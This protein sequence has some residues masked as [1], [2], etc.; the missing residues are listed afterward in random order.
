MTQPIVI[1][2]SGLA[3]Y[4]LAR[5]FRKLDRD[6]PLMILSRDAAGF[7]S[8]PMLSNALSAN[9]TAE[10]L[11]MKS[12]DKMAGEVLATIRPQVEIA[13][14]DRANRIVVLTSGERIAYRDLVLAIGADPIRLPIA[15]DGA[16]DILS[17]N[18]LDDFA[19]FA[20]RLDGA[21]RVVVLGAGLI[22]CEFANDLLARGI[23]PV[24]IDI[25]AW[26]LGRLLP[27]AAATWF[28]QQL[29]AAGVTFRM[30]TSATTVVR[31]G[32][33]YRVT[34][35]DGSVLDADLVLSAVGLRPRTALAHAAGLAVNRGIRVD[36]LL[37]T[38][39]AHIHALGDCAEVEGLVL[40][41][42]MP[43]MHQAR[44]LA[45]TLAGKPTAI[46]Y[47]AMPVVVKTPACPTVVC[48]PA[49]NAEGSW[50]IAPAANGEAGVE[51]Q[52]LA[53]DGALLGFTLLGAATARK[54]ALTTQAPAAL[55]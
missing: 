15:G 44:A 31:N 14:V 2:G 55:A 32:S 17:V 12:A 48:P 1:A 18:D 13:S 23:S 3:G 37:A 34:L 27:E 51:A 38:S 9:K 50:H 46:V 11:I 41:F 21:K 33:A 6:T 43:I 7:Y 30:N 45:A 26:P 10:S 5:E 53:P 52:F 54:Q 39:D 29:E 25:A 49:A 42:V 19:R 40:P 22:G 4:N 24:V 16:A 47:P 35:D 28:R 8:K 20:A 36:R